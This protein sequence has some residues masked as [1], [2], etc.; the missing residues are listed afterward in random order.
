VY[1]GIAIIG[2]ARL[3]LRT[4]IKGSKKSNKSQIYGIAITAFLPLNML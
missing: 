1:G 2:S 4:K 3:I